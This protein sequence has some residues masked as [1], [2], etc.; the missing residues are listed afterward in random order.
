[1]TILELSSRER[2]SL[3]ILAAQ[4]NSAKE[5]RRA[6]ALI[7]LNDGESIEE[8]AERLCVSRRTIYYWVEWFESS[9]GLDLASRLADAPRSGRPATAQGII[10]PLI[11]EVIETDPRDLGY[12]ST[13]WTAALLRQYLAEYHQLVICQRS[14]SYALARLGITW[15]RPRHDLS[16]CPDTWRQAKGGL[17]VGFPPASAP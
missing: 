15:K 9:V 3:E 11:D 6:Q 1:M 8:V 16:R 13:V 14:V 2:T 7:W 4:T 12:R 5:L 17:N 10:D